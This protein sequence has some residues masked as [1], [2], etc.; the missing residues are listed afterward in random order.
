[1]TSPPHEPRRLSPRRMVALGALV[2]VLGASGLAATQLD[3]DT[4]YRG[5]PLLGQLIPA[6]AVT[7]LDDAPLELRGLAGRVVIVNF[8]NTWCVPCRREVPAL[9]RFWARHANDADLVFLGIV[10]DDTK[11]AV[12]SWVEERRWD[13]TI[14]LDPDDR[15]ALAF[16]TTGQPETFAIAADG[17]VVGRRVGEASVDD[18][19]QL[20]AMARGQA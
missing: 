7:T 5:T 3:R 16:G 4:T 12:T 8:W 1:M 18:L 15:A 9:E 6:E 13:W 11:E 17:L 10:R 19:E 20:L 14:A 2:A